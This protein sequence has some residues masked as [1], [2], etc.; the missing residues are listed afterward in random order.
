VKWSVIARPVRLGEK[1]M[2]GTWVAE[3]DSAAEAVAYA[4]ERL[5]GQPDRHSVVV[6]VERTDA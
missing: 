6:T 2:T 4:A 5:R 1:D 3:A